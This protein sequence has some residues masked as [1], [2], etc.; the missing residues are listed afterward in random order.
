MR[1]ASSRALAKRKEEKNRKTAMACR[2][3]PIHP[4]EASQ[5][6]SFYFQ[7]EGQRG[8]SESIAASMDRSDG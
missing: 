1:P 7:R 3:V 5:A 2:V 6:V 8:V 4:K